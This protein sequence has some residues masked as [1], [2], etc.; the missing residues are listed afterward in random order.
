[1]IDFTYCAP[2]RYRF[3]HGAENHAGEELSALGCKKVLL[4]YGHSSAERSGLIARVE[5]S[6]KASSIQWHILKG[7]DPNPTDG[8]VRKGIEICR[9][10]GIDGLLA[11]GGGSVIDTAKAIAAG[12]LYQGDFWDFWA[13][14]AVITPRSP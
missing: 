3:G 8:P 4:V 14:K 6:L 12:V 13:G 2:T 7:I 10:E 1:M 9:R 11:V 5:A